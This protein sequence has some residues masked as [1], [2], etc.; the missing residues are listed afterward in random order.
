MMPSVSQLTLTL[1][2]GHAGDDA[3]RVAAGGRGRRGRGVD[4]GMLG[5]GGGWASKGGYGELKVRPS[6]ASVHRPPRSR[7]PCNRIWIPYYVPGL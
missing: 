1:T 5:M 2:L 6:A 7:S 4:E 3:Q